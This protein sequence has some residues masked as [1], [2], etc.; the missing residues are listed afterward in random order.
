[1]DDDD[2]T[3]MPKPAHPAE[4]VR[5]LCDPETAKLFAA[6]RGI[7]LEEATKRLREMAEAA[8]ERQRT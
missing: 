3:A 5:F 8:V 7:S 2:K 4:A 1:M 6:Q